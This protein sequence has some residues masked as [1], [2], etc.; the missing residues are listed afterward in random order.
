MRRREGKQEL[1]DAFRDA[2]I[3]TDSSPPCSRWLSEEVKDCEIEELE[4]P[5]TGGSRWLSE[6]VKDCELEELEPPRT[7][8][9][10]IWWVA[11]VAQ[12]VVDARELPPAKQTFS[13]LFCVKSNS[14]GERRHGSCS[15]RHAR[16]KKCAATPE[17]CWKR[18][19]SGEGMRVGRHCDGPDLGSGP[20]RLV[21]LHHPPPF[22]LLLSAGAM[23][24]EA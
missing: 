13:N 7:V 12:H 11:L 15:V 14:A 17:S 19:R 20:S 1:K 5:R 3:T 4:P 22:P 24:A 21:H 10:G 16:Q 9:A 6:E 23:D 8:G 18:K 2:G